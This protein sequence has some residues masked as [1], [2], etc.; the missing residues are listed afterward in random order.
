[1][2]NDC[3][4]MAD[5][6]SIIEEF[7]ELKIKI[8]FSEGR[9]NIEARE[10]IKITDVAPVVR[11]VDGERGE[12]NL[13]QRRWSWPAQNKRPVYNF[14]S[15]GREFT[16]NRCLVIADGFWNESHPQPC[17]TA[18][19]RTACRS[20]RRGRRDEIHGHAPRDKAENLKRQTPD[21]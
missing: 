21:T 5:I 4:L 8:R 7:A 1:M 17:G 12:G 20:Y 11:T 3:R 18:W 9:P 6:A 2:C 15:E 14:R 19:W 10:D 13:V 16:S